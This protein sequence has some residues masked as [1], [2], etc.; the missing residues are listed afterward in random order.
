MADLISVPSHV[1]ARI[2]PLR[3]IVAQ[4]AAVVLGVVAC[5]LTAGAET[6]VTGR[7]ELLQ[8]YESH[9]GVLVKMAVPMP[10]PDGCG[11][12]DWYILPDIANRAAFAQSMLLTAKSAGVSTW[13][14]I[15]GCF[16]G[17]PRILHITM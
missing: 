15:D 4:F 17:M 14:V 8:Q 16:Q 1:T 6:L 13:I 3:S 9:A 5:P 2:S 7:I 10:D 11:R 12:T